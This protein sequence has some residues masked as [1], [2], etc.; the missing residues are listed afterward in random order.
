MQFL[1]HQKKFL[2][3]TAVAIIAVLYG[4]YRYWELRKEKISL[5]GNVS[6]LRQQVAGLGVSLASTTADL[7][8]V[9]TENANLAQSLIAEQSKNQAFETQIHDISTTVGSLQ[10]LSTIDPQLLQKYSK[11]YFL[12]ENYAPAQ[13]SSVGIQYIYDKT[14]PQLTLPGVLPYLTAMI[15]ASNRDGAKL[16]V[17]SAYRSFYEQAALKTGYKMVYGSGANQF[18]A[19]QGYSE[20]QL[21]TAVDIT[22]QQLDDSLITNKFASS[23][24]YAWLKNNA[25]KYGFTLSYPPNNSYYQFEPWHWRFVGVGL[26]T[27]IQENNMYFYEM[28][29][30]DIDKY[31]INFFD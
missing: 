3:V 7:E 5:E 31:L 17:L 27:Y 18:S 4:G 25:Y 11:I 23:T 22:T 21:G 8:E 28:A 20:H 6:E 26:A 29:Q 13:L 30:R 12:S 1:N 19:D 10:K 15:D 24:A 2:L 14:K 9:R 16:L